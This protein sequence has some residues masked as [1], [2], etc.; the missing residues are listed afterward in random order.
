M[1]NMSDSEAENQGCQC[2]PVYDKNNRQRLIDWDGRNC[3][4]HHTSDPG[5]S[6]EP[7]E[8]SPPIPF[9]CAHCNE[10]FT[11]VEAA[12]HLSTHL[13]Q[14]H[15]GQRNSDPNKLIDKANPKHLRDVA[16]NGIGEWAGVDV[17]ARYFGHP[18]TFI[19]KTHSC[20]FL[21]NG[22]RYLLEVKELN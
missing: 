10:A 9:V 12:H 13:M 17:E 19:N 22:K 21:L 14:R 18:D 15:G 6:N 5:G 2:T 11:G 20:M 1:G 4:V 3:P 16:M 7:D 8:E